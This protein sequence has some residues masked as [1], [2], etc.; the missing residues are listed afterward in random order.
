MLFYV[1]TPYWVRECVWMVF[2]RDPDALS[3]VKRIGKAVFW[4]FFGCLESRESR[5]AISRGG[6]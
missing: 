2:L 1:K 4:V 3:G 5:I 6:E